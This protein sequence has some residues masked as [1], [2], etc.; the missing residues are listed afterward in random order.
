[1]ILFST[2]SFLNCLLCTYEFTGCRFINMQS[3]LWTKHVCVFYHIMIIFMIITTPWFLKHNHKTF[4]IIRIDF[5]F[6][7][8]LHVIFCQTIDI[9]EFFFLHDPPHIC[10]VTMSSKQE[11]WKLIKLL[12]W[13]KR[14]KHDWMCEERSQ[15]SMMN[16]NSFPISIQ[17]QISMTSLIK[18]L[19]LGFAMAYYFKSIHTCH[20]GLCRMWIF[21]FFHNLLFFYRVL[22][23]MVY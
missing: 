7:F 14:R 23:I 9:E 13:K 4:F 19:N 3:I 1:M 18:P 16:N 15:R 2:S 22:K 6:K 10:C 8:L 21:K 5:H 17:K 11:I 20:F 12:V